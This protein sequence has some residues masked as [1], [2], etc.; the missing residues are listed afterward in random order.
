MHELRKLAAGRS[1]EGRIKARH[2]NSSAQSH[3]AAGH[4]GSGPSLR[5]IAERMESAMH[6]SFARIREEL[7]RIPMSPDVSQ[8]VELAVLAGEISDKLA[9]LQRLVAGRT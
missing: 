3:T 7:H 9:E 8:R 6:E 4:A 2:G 5:T 1:R